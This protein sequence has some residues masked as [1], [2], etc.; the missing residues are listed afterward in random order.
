MNQSLRNHSSYDPSLLSW[1]FLWSRL[2]ELMW[3]QNHT[4]GVCGH[5]IN[6]VDAASTW[7]DSLL[8]GF[9]GRRF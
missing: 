4:S 2:M 1:Y 3:I 7:A 6:C 9:A 8:H 5:L